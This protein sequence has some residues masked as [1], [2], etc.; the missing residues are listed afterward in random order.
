MPKFKVFSPGPLP[1]AAVLFLAS[2]QGCTHKSPA[3]VAQATKNPAAVSAAGVV[4]AP[5]PL[6]EQPALDR[7]K[8]MSRKL[9]DTARFTYRARSTLEIPAR[10]GQFLTH[11][12]ESEVA[13]HRPDK[14]RFSLSGEV[15]N[16]RLYYDGTHV[17][18]LDVD[19]NLFATAEA[20]VTIDEM[21]PFVLDK[22]GIDLPAADFLFS[23]PYAEL[24]KGLTHAIVVGPSRVNGVKTEHFAFMNPESNWEIWIDTGPVPLPR[25]VAVTYKALENFPR[26]QIEFL[27]WNLTPRADIKQFEF[28]KPPGAKEIEFGSGLNKG[29]L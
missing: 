2:L 17:Y 29:G 19:K 10:T 7:L 4:P 20:P 27:D 14:L 6:I 5:P 18:A 23:D 22:V 8:A 26:F 12:A 24:T 1:L 28:R 11:F 16:F 9:A 21:L 13:L 3:P 25:R 15:P